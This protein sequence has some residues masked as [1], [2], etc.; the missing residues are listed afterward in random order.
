MNFDNKF[1]ES[2]DDA[3]LSIV[4]NVFLPPQLP[5]NGDSTEAILHDGALLRLV[6]CALREFQQHNNSRRLH[7]VKRA[8]KAMIHFQNIRDD[9]G[10]ID[11]QKLAELLNPSVYH[12]GISL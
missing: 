2:D 4:N 9:S 7:A 1:L 8:K 6:I 11:E 10:F 12:K 5:N 3:I